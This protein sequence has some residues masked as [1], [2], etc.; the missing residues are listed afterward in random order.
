MLQNRITVA[1]TVAEAK[2]KVWQYY[3]LPEHITQ[4]NFASPDWHC[5]AASNELVVGGTYRATMQA[6]DGSMGFDFE[7]VYEE[8]TL[9]SSLTYRITDGRQATIQFAETGAGTQVTIVFDAEQIH[10]PEL[11]Q[12]GWQ[13]ILN[14]FKAYTESN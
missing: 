7:A 13:A 2:H 1:A 10:A 8:V 4:W 5:P 3:T 6:K 14:N 9:G 12:A 11:Q